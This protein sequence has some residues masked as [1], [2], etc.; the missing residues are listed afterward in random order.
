MQNNVYTFLKS[1]QSLAKIESNYLPGIPKFTVL[2]LGPSASKELGLKIRSSLTS[3]NFKWSLKKQAL[4]SMSTSQKNK[5]DLVEADLSFIIKFLL[6]TRQIHLKTKKRIVALGEV[7]I[8]GEIKKTEMQNYIPS[9]DEVWIGNFS[10]NDQKG[11]GVISIK[12]LSDLTKLKLEDFNFSNKTDYNFDFLDLVTMYGCHSRLLLNDDL[13]LLSVKVQKFLSFLNQ[14]SSIEDKFEFLDINSLNSISYLKKCLFN[15]NRRIVCIQNYSLLNTNVKD[16]INKN[17]KHSMI[18]AKTDLCPCGKAQLG[19]LKKCGYSLQKCRS[20]IEKMSKS[21]LSV[22]DVFQTKSETDQVK[23]TNDQVFDV[24][25]RANEL[26]K[27]RESQGMEDEIRFLKNQM[28]SKLSAV[29]HLPMSLGEVRL[30][31]CLKLA[32]SI[33]DLRGHSKIQQE[34][35][36]L[37]LSYC[38]YPLKELV[39]LF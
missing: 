33:A 30:K 25:R 2:D 23:F 26:R 36:D 27:S 13:D 17:S 22:F 18:L 29:A 3:K 15:E 12:S 35:L 8:H 19:K 24:W 39:S 7:S 31:K 14:N 6:D 37:S 9:Y 11:P 4:F 21:E 34:D 32:L 28:D 20:V 10:Q 1:N 5:K 16:H 38:F